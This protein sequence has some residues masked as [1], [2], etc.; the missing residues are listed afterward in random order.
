MIVIGADYDTNT[1]DNPMFNNGAGVAAMLETARMFMHN[2]HWSGEYMQN[3][4][5]VFVAF[6]LNTREHAVSD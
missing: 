3:Y 2:T 5:T 1:K 6:D 4:T